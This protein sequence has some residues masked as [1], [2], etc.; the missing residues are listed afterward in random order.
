MG[1]AGEPLFF[2]EFGKSETA[3]DERSWIRGGAL[4]ILGVRKA[5]HA[6]FWCVTPSVAKQRL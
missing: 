4:R 6:A 2:S 1:G 3:L 5:E